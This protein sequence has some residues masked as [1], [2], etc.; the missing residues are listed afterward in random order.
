MPVGIDISPG[1]LGVA[2]QR[3]PNADLRESDM[4]ELPF[5]GEAFDAV[6]GI[7]AFQFT[8]D[9]LRALREAARVLRPGGRLVAS[10]FAAPERSQLTVVQ[11][12]VSALIPLEAAAD[13]APYALSAPGGL[14]AAL[15]Q[16]GLRVVGDGEVLCAWRYASMDDAVAGNLSSAGGVRAKEAAGE[17]AVR[18]VLREALAQFEDPGTGVVTM[19]NIFRWVAAS[20]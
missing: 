14:E 1:L 13:H 16:A 19:D 9:P 17:A 3:L 5:R 10:L 18:E 2:R 11:E 8:G 12:A 20:R 7:S 6:L 15:G 4:E